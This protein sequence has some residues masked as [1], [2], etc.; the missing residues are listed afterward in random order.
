MKLL[1]DEYRDQLQNIHDTSNWGVSG[2][3][4]VERIASTYTEYECESCVDYGSGYG[5]TARTLWKNYGIPRDCVQEY[6]PG[7]PEKSALPS[8]ADLVYCTDVLEH[9][10]PELIDDVLT[11][12]ASLIK[13]VGFFTIGL[14]PSNRCLPDGRDAHLILESPK[15]WRAKLKPHF[16]IVRGGVHGPKDAPHTYR[17]V[18]TKK[19]A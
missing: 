5:R 7:I 6:E 10:E 1:T 18:V 12:I 3:Y 8:P 17:V 16:N 4:W 11:H 19:E 2:T 9:V 15:W 14:R 13:K